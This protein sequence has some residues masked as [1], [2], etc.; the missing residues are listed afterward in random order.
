MRPQSYP[1]KG[2]NSAHTIKPLLR[3]KHRE[4]KNPKQ[5]LTQ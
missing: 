1:Y 3:K 5:K 2:K 4:E